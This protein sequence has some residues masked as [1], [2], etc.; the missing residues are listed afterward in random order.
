MSEKERESA[1]RQA[2]RMREI[3]KERQRHTH[4]DREKE[5]EP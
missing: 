5:M 2:D 4:R 1:V 3:N